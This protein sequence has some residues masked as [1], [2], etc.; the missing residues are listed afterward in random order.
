MGLPDLPAEV[1]RSLGNNA[2]GFLVVKWFHFDDFK[3][4]R[5]DRL[6]IIGE[7]RIDHARAAVSVEIGIRY[8]IALAII[9]GDI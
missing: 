7:N 1:Q 8:D 6:D 4:I 9:N 3:V 2:D 5:P